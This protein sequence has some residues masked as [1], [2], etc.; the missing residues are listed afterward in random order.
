MATLWF[1]LLA[2]M[3]T[4]YVVLDGFDLGVGALHRI[5]ARD[6]AER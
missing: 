3:I 6:D 5:L 2:L 4:V 1:V